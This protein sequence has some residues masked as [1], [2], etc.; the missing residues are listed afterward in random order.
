MNTFRHLSILCLAGFAAS[1][2]AA[3]DV[4]G[5]RSEVKAGTYLGDEA[6]VGCA[7]RRSVPPLP[8]T[9]TPN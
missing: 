8:N 7:I 2:A 5:T 3:A 1:P 4:S 9:C 6:A